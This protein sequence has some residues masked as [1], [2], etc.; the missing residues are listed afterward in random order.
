MPAQDLFVH[1]GELARD[2]RRAR[3]G[4]AAAS[5]ASV[6]ASRCGDSNSTTA[7]GVGATRASASRAPCPSRGRNPRSESP[8]VTSPDAATAAVTADAPGIGTTATPASIAALH[9]RRARIAHRGRARVGHERDALSPSA[10]RST[11]SLDLAR[12][13]VRVERVERLAL[14]AEV[15][16]QRARAARVLGDDAIAAVRSVSTAR[17]VMSPRLPIGVATT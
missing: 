3:R 15:R 5:S 12:A 14:D 4:T 6:A 10:S 16:E 9:E 8:P 17:S 11:T 2:D 13:G 7:S 1:L